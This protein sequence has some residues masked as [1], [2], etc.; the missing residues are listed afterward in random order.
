MPYR[1]AGPALVDLLGGK[2]IWSRISAVVAEHLVKDGKLKGY[3]NVGGSGSRR[4][5]TADRLAM[6]GYNKLDVDF[7]HM[8]LAPAGTP[9]ADR[10]E[11]NAALTHG[12]RPNAKVAKTSP[13]AASTNSRPTRKRRRP[14]RNAQGEI[15][16]VGRQM[17]RAQPACGTGSDQ[18]YR[19]NL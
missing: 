15:A 6:L 12:A 3:A 4:C 13:M 7:W 14:R 11:A 19:T 2:S 16:L 10:R 8:L 17:V 9:R 1:G 18:I 5:R